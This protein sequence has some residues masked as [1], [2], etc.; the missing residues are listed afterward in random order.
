MPS[1][2]LKRC[3]RNGLQ[4]KHNIAIAD[5]ISLMQV[6]LLLSFANGMPGADDSP[7][8]RAFS[9]AVAGEPH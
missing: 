9:L 8:E 1:T 7:V 2:L 6:L 3:I 5:R 4:V